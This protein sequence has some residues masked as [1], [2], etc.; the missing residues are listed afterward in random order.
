MSGLVIIA[1]KEFKELLSNRWVLLVIVAL[2]V[3]LCSWTYDFYSVLSGGVPGAEL[4]FGENLGVAADNYVFFGMCW[5]GTI[6]GV[7]IGCSTISAE[8]IGNALNTLVV[9]PVYRDTIINGKL[10]GSLAFLVTI[11][12]FYVAF[13]TRYF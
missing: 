6:L 7:I 9:K 13:I 5:F 12:A 11:M 8:R 4:M 3:Y 10:L 1:G 2:L